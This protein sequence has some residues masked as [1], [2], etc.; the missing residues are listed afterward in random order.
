MQ[1]LKYEFIG[2]NKYNLYLSNGEVLE[3]SEEVITQNQ[4]LFKK[5]IDQELY[6]KINADNKIYQFFEIAAK[7]ISLRLR[8]IKEIR[9][10]L[11]KK[12][13]SDDEID[14]VID[15]LINTG[16]LDDDRFTQAFINDKLNFTTMGDYKIRLEL[17]KLGVS[18]SIIEKNISLIDDELIENKIKKVIDKDIRTNK[19]YK[20]IALKNKIYNH[21]LTSGY[22]KEKVINIINN[23]DF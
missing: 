7:Y 13:A 11:Q 23:Y 16:Y 21:L 14:L 6:Y 15:K 22:S 9:D 2:K 17:D 5:K 19:K 3:L 18:Q 20:G 10:Y 12:G 4:L 1:I 8:S